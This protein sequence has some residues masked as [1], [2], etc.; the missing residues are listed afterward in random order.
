MELY[1]Q[2]NGRFVDIPTVS[3]KTIILRFGAMSTNLTNELG[4]PP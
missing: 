4:A 2:L 1:T 3:P